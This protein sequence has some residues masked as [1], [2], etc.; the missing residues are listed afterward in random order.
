VD[1]ARK[2]AAADMAF[3]N[4]GTL[5]DLEQWVGAVMARFRRGVVNGAG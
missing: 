5:D 1:E 2:V 4:D 3:V